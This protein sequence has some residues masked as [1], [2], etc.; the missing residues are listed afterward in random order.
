M[1]YVRKAAYHAGKL[2]KET[3]TALASGHRA[4]TSRLGLIGA[5]A[6]ALGAAYVAYRARKAERDHLQ[7]HA[8]RLHREI[9]HSRLLTQPGLGHMLHYGAP[10]VVV[11]AVN[12]MAPSAGG[13]DLPLAG[14]PVV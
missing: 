2:V 6:L 4:R 10:D 3:S 7:R 13:T 14:M 11:N 12:A 9:P 8:V 5:G 1:R